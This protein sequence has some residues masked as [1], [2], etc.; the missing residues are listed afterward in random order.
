MNKFIT[1]FWLATTSVV[2]VPCAVI[3]QML[4]MACRRPNTQ[5]VYKNGHIEKFFFT[6]WSLNDGTFKWHCPTPKAPKRIAVDEIMTI[7]DLY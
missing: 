5:I 3:S 4:R 7:T 2:Y 6:D 1:K